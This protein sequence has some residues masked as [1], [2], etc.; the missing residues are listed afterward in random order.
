MRFLCPTNG[1]PHPKKQRNT[2]APDERQLVREDDRPNPH[3]HCTTCAGVDDATGSTHCRILRTVQE[4]SHLPSAFR[5][6]QRGRGGIP[7]TVWNYNTDGCIFFSDILTPLPG[8]GVQFD[9]D[10]K[11]GPVVSP[12]RTWDDI[13]KMYPIDPSSVAPFVAQALR[14]LREEVLPEM[15]VLGFVGCPYTLATYQG[16]S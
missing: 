11:V 10:E 7:T 6:T 1:T 12:R 3:P 15:A 4:V 9:I 5:D 8:L 14:T 13:K 16:L 2:D